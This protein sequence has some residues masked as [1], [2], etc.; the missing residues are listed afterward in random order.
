MS[1]LIKWAVE[2]PALHRPVLL[3]A[4]DGFVDAGGAGATAAMFLRHRWRSEL[5]ATFDRDAL[6]DYRARRPTAVVD[7]GELRRVEW[8]ELELLR[9]RVGARQDALLLVGPEPDMRWQ[10][11]FEEVADVCRRL[12]VERV[13]A[14]GAYPAAR[15]HTRPIRVTRAGNAP[16]RDLVPEA[17]DVT[18]YTG[19][20]GASAA[21]LGALAE[22]EVA[23]VGLWAEI[24]HYI[25]GS[26][27]PAGA[28]ALARLV[29]DA[30][31][32]RVD[33]TELEAAARLFRDQVD[34]AVAEHAEARQMVE[35]LERQLDSG[36]HDAQLPTGDD[37][38]A[39]IERFLR[40]Q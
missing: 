4:L 22:R 24:P 16:G 23:A 29:T 34:E 39:E 35:S 13:V 12:D 17:S 26:P 10:A 20:V 27:N 30:L 7:S 21:L 25:A 3:V 33:T 37:L 8:P 6:L 31:G 19:P 9:A 15:P 38:A 5:L 36:A 14:L 11:F 32:V 28:V 18:G 1:E 40:S 2:P